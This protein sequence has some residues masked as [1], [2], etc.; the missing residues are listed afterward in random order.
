MVKAIKKKKVSKAKKKPISKIKK[1][2]LTKKVP[3][4][5]PKVINQVNSVDKQ[6]VQLTFAVL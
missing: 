4:S 3:M 5:K 1:K 6:L 2:P